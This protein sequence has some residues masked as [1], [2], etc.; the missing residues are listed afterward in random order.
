MYAARP[1]A[2]QSS[3]RGR[4]GR[5]STVVWSECPG[6]GVCGRTFPYILRNS[7]PLSARVVAT[8]NDGCRL[9]KGMPAVTSTR[10]WWQDAVVY[11]AYPRSFADAG[12]DGSGDR[13]RR[14]L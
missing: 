10:Q 13:D 2:S 11:E 9:E 6:A 1:A 5:R 14:R 8:K 12:G 3:A 4:T 7:V